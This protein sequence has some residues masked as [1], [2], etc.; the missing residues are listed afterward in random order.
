MANFYLKIRYGRARLVFCI[1]RL[2]CIRKI[3]AF[4][5]KNLKLDIRTG[6]NQALGC[7]GLFFLAFSEGGG[8]SGPL[9]NTETGTLTT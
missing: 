6:K 8:V 1:Q 4:G 2:S 5:F 7:S 3:K 9:R